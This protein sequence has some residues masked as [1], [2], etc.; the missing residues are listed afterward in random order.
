MVENHNLM[1]KIIC[2]G[3]ILH[4][5]YS[6]KTFN[7]LNALKSPY[8]LDQVMIVLTP[9]S[10]GAMCVHL[11]I[12]YIEQVTLTCYMLHCSQVQN[13]SVDMKIRT[14]YCN[15]SEGSQKNFIFFAILLLLREVLPKS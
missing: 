9:M 10:H 12:F 7:Q 13:V 14:F 4:H 15:Q 11:N 2:K 3:P 5:R 1:P 6:V 8:P